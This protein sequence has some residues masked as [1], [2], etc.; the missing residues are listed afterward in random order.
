MKVLLDECIP[1]RLGQ[2]FG[3]HECYGVSDLGWSG[4]KNGDLLT[5]AEQSGVEAF[6]TVDQGI[7]Y[8]Q[9]I[10]G[11]PLG[12]VVLKAKSSRYSDLIRCVPELLRAI[13]SIQPGQLIHISSN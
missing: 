13:S 7:E 3:K 6:V 8:E 11:R 9:N 5:L 4:K 12:I 2:H 10:A 1:R